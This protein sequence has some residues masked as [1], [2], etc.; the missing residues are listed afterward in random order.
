MTTLWTTYSSYTVA[1]RAVD[2]LTA[3][4]VSD[5][6]IRLI[7]GSRLH[8]LRSEVAG[9]FAGPVGPNAPVGRFAGPPLPRWHA[10]GGF[11]GDPNRW[12]QGSFADTEQ[13]LVVSYD[14]GTPRSRVTG[15]HET[16]RLLAAAHLNERVARR[17]IDELHRD[18]AAVLAEVAEIAPR[19]A[20]ARLDQLAR[21]A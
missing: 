8:D 16:A 9:G 2:E 4:G 20:Q 14:R 13:N 12:R 18:H 11:Y 3:A 15:D 6:D 19:E 5:R 10:A 17:I 7:I 21:A 1:Q